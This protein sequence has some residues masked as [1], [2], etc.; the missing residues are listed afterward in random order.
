M[1]VGPDTKSA[2]H[3]RRHER[4][5]LST[6]AVPL[7]F[8]ARGPLTGPG[9][10]ALRPRA[11]G[12]TSRGTA[13]R[14]LSAGDGLSLAGMPP[15]LL[16]PFLA[17]VSP[18][19]LVYYHVP[20][21]VSRRPWWGRLDKISISEHLT[22]EEDRPTHGKQKAGKQDARRHKRIEDNG[23]LRPHTTCA[24]IVCRS[25][26]HSENRCTPH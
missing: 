10:G 8:L 7:S 11:P 20:E 26:P 12:C 1:W 6:Y 19:S 14:P 13:V 15:A 9:R 21:N 4:R 2:S 18:M 24:Q 5:R 16:F 23:I 3:A 22:E 17:P 25:E